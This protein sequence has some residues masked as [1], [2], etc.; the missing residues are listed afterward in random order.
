MTDFEKREWQKYIDNTISHAIGVVEYG[1]YFYDE[2]KGLADEAKD[3]CQVLLEDYVR[4]GTKSRCN[5]LKKKIDVR[6]SELEDEV[7]AFIALE[8]PKIIEDENEFLKKNVQPLFKIQLEDAA[9]SIT[10]LAMIPVATAGAAIEF[11]LLISNKLRDIYNSEITQSYI[12]GISFNELKD[13][14]AIR[15]NSF[16]RGL[17]AD[18][19]TLG[20]SLGNQ[21][22]RM[23]YTKNKDKIPAYMWS[24]ILDTS[25]CI[26]CGILDHKIFNDILKVPLYP[27]HANCVSGDTLISSVSDISAIF[28]RRYEGKVYIITMASGNKLTITPNHPILT[29]RGF[30]PVKFLHVRDNVVC[31]NGLK[32]I[33]IFSKDKNDINT[34]AEQLFSTFWKSSQVVSCPVELS[35]EDFNSDIV[36]EKIN[37][38][39][40]D[41]NLS[42]EGDVILFKKRSKYIFIFRNLRFLFKKFTHRLSTFFFVRKSST[43]DNSMTLFCQRFT[44]LRSCKLHS[45]NLLFSTISLMNSIFSK[46]AYHLTSGGSQPLSNTRNTNSLIIKLHNFIQ[47]KINRGIDSRSVNTSQ[48]DCTVNSMDTDPQL[49]SYLFS[50]HSTQ[51]KFDSIVS[52]EITNFS[53]H[54]YNLET[55]DN[56][57]IAN[58]VVTHNCR[59]ILI[60]INNEIKSEDFESYTEWF[61]HQSP[62]EKRAILGK[63]R[64]QLYE[65]GMK[66]KQFVN[67]NKKTPLKTLFNNHTLSS[68]KAKEVLN[69]QKPVDPAILN[70]VVNGLRKNGYSIE[71]GADTDRLLELQGKEAYVIATNDGKAA[72]VFHSKVSASG[73]FEEVIHTAQIRRHSYEYFRTHVHEL[74]VEAKLKLLKYSKSYGITEYEKEIIKEDLLWHQSQIKE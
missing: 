54:V 11:G 58:G 63:T 3:D 8:L 15:L 34:T 71:I 1:N 44:L 12:T 62:K 30:I 74:E 4:C 25:T 43:S 9:K 70:Q 61:E 18:A 36:N 32:T 60:P 14:Y 47:R 49:S 66:I 69:K 2:I 26:A 64:F 22:Q 41:G 16:D 55:K 5:E 57:Y 29:D 65:Q 35:T 37:V 31:D 50:C 33:N 17:E 40:S 20:A 51:I 45:F 72:I 21:Y 53:G 23:V 19:N 67:N 7:A 38:V 28:R 59:C 42:K 68:D 6:L 10:K 56:Y 52:I 13:D 46:K 24:A 48:L 27:V 39:R 73:L